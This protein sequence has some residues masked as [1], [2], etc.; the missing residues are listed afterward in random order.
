MAGYW[1]KKA[2]NQGSPTA[3]YTLAILYLN[4]LYGL[5]ENG[6]IDYKSAG[7]Y[8]KKAADQEHR[9]AQ[10]YLGK[11][12]EEG[13][14]GRLKNG[15]PNLER[16]SFYLEKNEE[17]EGID[18]HLF[19]NHSIN[20]QRDFVE[21]S[22]PKNS[23]EENSYVLN[24]NYFN[25]EIQKIKNLK[26]QFSDEFSDIKKIFSVLGNEIINDE[27]ELQN[28]YHFLISLGLFEDDD[29]RIISPV[30]R[31]LFA[32]LLDL[33]NKIYKDNQYENFHT[34]LWTLYTCSTGK[35]NT[36]LNYSTHIIHPDTMDLMTIMKSEHLKNLSTIDE[37]IHTY[38]Y[39]LTGNLIE[40]S[41]SDLELHH[42]FHCENAMIDSDLTHNI[43]YLRRVLAGNLFLTDPQN[44]DK[45]PNCVFYS[46]AIMDKEALVD[47]L[48]S[49]FT[50]SYFVDF[51]QKEWNEVLNNKSL[52]GKTSLSKYNFSSTELFNYVGYQHVEE[53]ED[54]EANDVCFSY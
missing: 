12:Y 35:S 37:Y 10:K 42:H 13:K 8:F 14:Y 3:Q 34:Y 16:A 40:N 31:A 49:Y 17:N 1:F 33:K 41:L 48:Y 39:K 18:L 4:G 50:P 2:A 28:S 54:K 7:N 22:L 45:Y 19:Y 23:F 25:L 24:L 29:D 6:S 44:V 9:R 20:I 11:M 32:Y 27:P 15:L 21:F 26:E 53:I 52:F 43:S 46:L 47:K 38:I 5:L 30:Q 51:F 36:I